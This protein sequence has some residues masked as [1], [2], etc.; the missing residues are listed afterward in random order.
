MILEADKKKCIVCGQPVEYVFDEQRLMTRPGD[1]TCRKTCKR[2]LKTLSVDWD[3]LKASEQRVTLAA[4]K[5]ALSVIDNRSGKKMPK[6]RFLD[7]IDLVHGA[8]TGKRFQGVFLPD[9]CSIDFE[10]FYTRLKSLRKWRKIDSAKRQWERWKAYALKHG[11]G[12]PYTE[13]PSRAVKFTVSRTII[14]KLSNCILDM[15]R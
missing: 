4:W 1:K 8:P 2:I 15:K 6:E 3:E 14:K 12:I 5:L 13:D 7:L 11:L 9:P 10:H